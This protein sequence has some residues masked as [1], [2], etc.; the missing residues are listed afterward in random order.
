MDGDDGLAFEVGAFQ[1]ISIR[2]AER[3]VIFGVMS[4]L[5][6]KQRRSVGRTFVDRRV[7]LQNA[8]GGASRQKKLPVTVRRHRLLEDSLAATKKVR[9]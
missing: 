8:L 2:S 1:P 9:V 5:I 6:E 4:E 3:N 7:F